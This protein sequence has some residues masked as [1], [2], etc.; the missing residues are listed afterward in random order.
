[1]KTDYMKPK[2]LLPHLYKKIGW[3][4]TVPFLTYAVYAYILGDIFNL[5]FKAE[6]LE[7]KFP[8]LGTIVLIGLLGGL[9]LVSFSKEKTEDEYISRLRL[10]SLQVAVIVN[11]VLLILA[12]LSFFGLDFLSVMVYNMFTVLLIFIIR[13]HFLL[14]R[15]KSAYEK[16]H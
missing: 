6:N 8:W 1:M 9:L 15:N 10:E 3:A 13:F 2:Y 12:A 16:Q 14:Y 4:L 7:N 5:P 11:Y